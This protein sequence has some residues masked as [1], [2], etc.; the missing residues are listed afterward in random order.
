MEIRGAGKS[1][2]GTHAYFPLLNTHVL[3]EVVGRRTVSQGLAR[4][5]SFHRDESVGFLLSKDNAGQALNCQHQRLV[6]D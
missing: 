2:A 3:V 1:H 6:G 5:L 4:R